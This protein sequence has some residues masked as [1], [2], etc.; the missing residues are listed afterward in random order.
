MNDL[1]NIKSGNFF[2]Y[3]ENFFL[4]FKNVLRFMIKSLDQYRCDKTYRDLYLK[5]VQ[6]YTNPA[7]LQL[8]KDYYKSRDLVNCNCKKYTIYQ[9]LEGEKSLKDV[10]SLLTQFYRDLVELSDATRQ[11][12]EKH[13][14][15]MCDALPYVDG[16]NTIA[17]PCS[18]CMQSECKLCCVP[19]PL[20]P[21]TVTLWFMTMIGRIRTGCIDRNFD[22]GVKYMMVL[23]AIVNDNENF[24]IIGAALKKIA[25]RA[26]TGTMIPRGAPKFCPTKCNTCNNCNTSITN[27]RI[28]PLTAQHGYNCVNCRY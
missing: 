16:L 15:S 21:L 13:D 2:S 22:E 24:Q 10:P 25:Q 4:G 17:F 12:Y 27:S 6:L 23:T 20:L 18:T 8:S 7:L 5:V 28:A 26:T 3:N 19:A 1:G 14:V 11:F 9:F